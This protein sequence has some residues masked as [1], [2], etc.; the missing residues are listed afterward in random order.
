MKLKNKWFTLVELIVLITIL[1]ILWI[2][3]I[4]FLQSY[5]L[6]ARDWA[7]ISDIKSIQR[8][9]WL[10]IIQ[11]S[12]FPEPTNPVNITYSWA[13][14][15]TQWT[16]WDTT[17]MNVWIVN[18]KPIDPLKFVDYSY[19]IT[20]D[21][22]DY[23]IWWVME[24]S[25]I[26]SLN[27]IINKTNAE[28]SHTRAYVT[29]PY[30]WLATK[31]NTWWVDYVLA[32]PSILTNNLNQTDINQIYSN[33]SFVYNNY[34]NLPS[35]FSW[36]FNTS[37]WFDFVPKKL[38]LYT[39]SLN[40]LTELSNQ[41]LLLQNIQDSYSWAIILNDDEQIKKIVDIGIDP[42]NP[43]SKAKVL[44]CTVINFSV[45]HFVECNDIDYVTYYV[46]NVLHI[47]I[48]NLPWNTIN[49]VVQTSNWD[50]RF[51]TDWWVWYY[52]W[53]T[54]TIYNTWN[55]WIVSN[56]VLAM[57]QASDWN[58][59]FGTNLWI[60]VFDWT[61]WATLNQQNS[62][63]KQNHIL[64]IFTWT[65]WKM[66]IWTN[67]WV[68]T[69]DS[70]VWQSYTKQNTWITHNQVNAI[71]EDNQW[72]IWFGTKQWLD[73][74]KNWVVTKYKTTQ[75]LINN[76]VFYIMQDTSNN[77]RFWTHS[78]ISKFNWTTFSNKTT[79]NTSWWLPSNYITYIYQNETNWDM[80]FGTNNW[81]AKYVEWTN[82]WTTYNTSNQLS[83]NDIHSINQNNN[84]DIIIMNDWWVDTIT[85]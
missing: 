26:A 19:S 29:W 79:T 48:T 18:K 2:I 59:W 81:A 3:A 21:K 35:N 70:W 45:K 44:A 16:F 78:W 41:L 71:Y 40:D 72:N 38:V 37:F 57:A 74:F 22:I 67:A 42:Q 55:S 15:W 46:I 65:D 6:N 9:L 54:W 77:M 7:R 1:S 5:T 63:L 31:V 64:E 69:Y 13:T 56:T 62:W 58:M 32:I 12:R 53:T 27:P 50:L 11:R 8:A 28:T 82:T 20:N 36:A 17:F 43:S 34:W 68:S 66:R 49:S 61:T 10:Y 85:N 30:N 73:K 51:G 47:D 23:L 75:W 60:S 4:L 33:K 14:V 39:W 24:S 83:W 76:E 84:W 80:W 52:N 25:E